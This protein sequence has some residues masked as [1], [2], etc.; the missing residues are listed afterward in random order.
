LISPADDFNDEDAVDQSCEVYEPSHLVYAAEGK[1]MKRLVVY[2]LALAVALIAFA[3]VAEAKTHKDNYSV[4]CDVLWR[5]VKDTI[6]NSGKYGIIGIDNAELA[7]SFNIGGS[8][9]GKRINS[10]V[11]NRISEKACEMQTQT[12]FS[13]LVNNDAGDFKKRVDASL[14]KLSKEQVVAE[15][16]TP[17]KTVPVSTSGRPDALKTGLSTEEVEKIAGKPVD[18]VVL[19]DTVVYLYSS[20]K[21]VMEKGVVVEVQD[22][23]MKGE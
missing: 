2:F 23:E 17:E 15:K 10:V 3:P 19:K 16:A 13:G 7:A 6:R 8:L 22:R 12:A 18:K 11:L 5:A 9:A 14:D 21:V 1:I 4:S 20:Y